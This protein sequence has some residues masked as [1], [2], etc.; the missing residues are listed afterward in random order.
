MQ[1]YLNSITGFEDAFRAMYMSKRSWNKEWDD[2]MVRAGRVCTTGNGMPRP[3][4]KG[5]ECWTDFT[6]WVN[7]LCKWKNHITLLKFIDVSVTVDGLHR[8]GCDDLDSH[9]KRFDNRIIRSSTRLATYETEEI[10]DWYKNK[11]IP[12]DIALSL[13]N[14]EMPEYMIVDGQNYVKTTNGYIREDLKDNKDV[15]RGLYMLSLPMTFTFK[16]NLAELAHVY[17]ERGSK[18][19]GAHGTAAP[20]L[21]ELMEDLMSQIEAWHPQFNRQLMLDIPN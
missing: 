12:T 4:F 5:S 1:V 13:L 6:K 15:K 3:A 7:T 10:S 18:A 11:I 9:A 14:K 2:R 21:Q 19:G 17:K 20:E 16:V 8:G